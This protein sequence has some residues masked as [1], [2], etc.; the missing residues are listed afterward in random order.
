MEETC[1][2]KD[3]KTIHPVLDQE[4]LNKRCPS[5]DCDKLQRNDSKYIC[6]RCGM[7]FSAG[8]KKW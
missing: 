3:F 4:L 1:V 7:S 8:A 5:C 2:E 6:F